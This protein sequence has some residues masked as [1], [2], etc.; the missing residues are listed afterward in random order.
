MEQTER[1]QIDK[2]ILSS[3]CAAL[4][5]PLHENSVGIMLSLSQ[6]KALADYVLVLEQHIK[7][8]WPDI[9]TYIYPTETTL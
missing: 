2:T 7:G 9:E 1:A 8:D 5:N 3:A 6:R 4:V